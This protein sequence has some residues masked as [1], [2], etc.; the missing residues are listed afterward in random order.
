[1]MITEARKCYGKKVRHSLYP[2]E[3]FILLGVD[4][5]KS[6]SGVWDYDYQACLKLMDRNA[7]FFTPLENVIKIPED[8]FKRRWE[9]G[10]KT[11]SPVGAQVGICEMTGG[12]KDD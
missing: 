1:M 11:L 7:C 8:P 10:M 6:P 4:R 12:N 9:P 2:K 3:E 5:V